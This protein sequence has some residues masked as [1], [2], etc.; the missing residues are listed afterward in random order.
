MKHVLKKNKT[1]DRIMTHDGPAV[2]SKPKY[3]FI[4]KFCLKI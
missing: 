4:T 1:L 3:R 2:T